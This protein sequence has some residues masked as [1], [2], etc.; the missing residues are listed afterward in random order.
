MYGVIPLGFTL[1][2]VFS[3]PFYDNG[4]IVVYSTSNYSPFTQLLLTF[5]PYS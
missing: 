1:F 5:I 4:M 3:F 2:Y